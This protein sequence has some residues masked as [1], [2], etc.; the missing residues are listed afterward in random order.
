MQAAVAVRSSMRGSDDPNEHPALWRWPEGSGFKSRP[1]M[2][3]HDV[4][5]RALDYGFNRRRLA[6]GANNGQHA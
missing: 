2:E 5:D 6:A 4:L 1:R 3:V